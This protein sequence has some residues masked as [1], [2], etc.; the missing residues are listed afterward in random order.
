MKYFCNTS[1]VSRYE[2]G[3]VM[4]L[5]EYIKK[6]SLFDFSICD[7]F[8]NMGYSQLQVLA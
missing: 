6:R 2:V 1:Y 4:I 5:R 8:V 3:I 7:A